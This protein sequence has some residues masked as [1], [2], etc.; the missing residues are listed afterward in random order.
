MLT[1]GRNLTETGEAAAVVAA[2]AAPVFK[3][4]V[5]KHPSVHAY[6]EEMK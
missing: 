6:V 2:V 5:L 4:G 3:Q 1:E